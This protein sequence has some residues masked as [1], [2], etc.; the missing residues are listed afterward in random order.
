MI[1]VR[2]LPSPHTAERVEK[3][4]NEVLTEWQTPRTKISAILTDNGSNMIAAFHDWLNGLQSESEDEA[5]DEE[6][7]SGSTSPSEEDMQ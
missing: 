2:R 6:P 7:K 3:I 1:T 4:V 5:G